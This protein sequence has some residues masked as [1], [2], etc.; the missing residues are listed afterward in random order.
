M[1]LHL[2]Y[3]VLLF[4]LYIYRWIFIADDGSW[5]RNVLLQMFLKTVLALL[6]IIKL[7]KVPDNQP[8]PNIPYV[9]PLQGSWTSPRR[10]PPR[11][12]LTRWPGTFSH[13]DLQIPHLESFVIVTFVRIK[14]CILLSFV[15]EKIQICVI[16]GNFSCSTELIGIQFVV[17]YWICPG[18]TFGLLII[19]WRFSTSICP[20]W[21][22][23]MY[24]P[25]SSLVGRYALVAV[26]STVQCT[27]QCTVQYR[28]HTLQHR[29]VY[30]TVQ[31][32][33]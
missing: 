1:C 8:N 23:V 6:F 29:T 9:P 33:T 21:L 17:R 32:T 3:F 20:C 15:R 27:V 7:R 22:D 4:L 26:Y 19:L 14:M 31:C 11:W 13:A 2:Y 16:V 18:V 5:T 25:K 30:S 28:S 12:T 10:R 24:Q